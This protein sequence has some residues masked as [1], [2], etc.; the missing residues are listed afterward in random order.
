MR[1][2]KTACHSHQ[3][4]IFEGFV[5]SGQRSPHARKLRTMPPFGS[6]GSARSDPRNRSC[7][8]ADPRY[9]VMSPPIMQGKLQVPHP[10]FQTAPQGPLF[11]QPRLRKNV[12]L[13][14][15]S[16]I[17]LAPA[18]SQPP[19][20]AAKQP[21]RQMT[22]LRAATSRPEVKIAVGQE[23]TVLFGL[24]SGQSPSARAINNRSLRGDGP[25]LRAQ[26]ESFLQ[27]GTPSGAMVRRRR[28]PHYKEPLWPHRK[29]RSYRHLS[30]RIVHRNVP[31]CWL[32]TYSYLSLIPECK[33][34]CLE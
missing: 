12:A 2:L 33:C 21:L 31:L 4:G 30:D 16:P 7:R 20:H 27:Q 11:S 1:R 22:L 23:S 25:P 26:T 28:Y 14:R 32:H 3:M 13:L 17:W 18:A 29:E 15:G 19:R 24:I 10:R 34:Q 9:R 8:S 5:R 6:A